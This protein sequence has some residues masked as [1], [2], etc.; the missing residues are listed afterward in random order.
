MVASITGLS[1]RRDSH[2]LSTSH[3]IFVS[4]RNCFNAAAQ[5]RAR[6]MSPIE[7]GLM[8]RSVFSGAKR[9]RESLSVPRRDVRP[10]CGEVLPR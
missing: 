7:P 2:R 1:V 9:V 6:M 5:G 8:R 4:G 3:V 10:V